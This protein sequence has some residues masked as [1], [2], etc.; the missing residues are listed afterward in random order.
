[1]TTKQTSRGLI[2]KTQDYKETSKLLFV[3]TPKGKKTLVAKG[4]KSFKSDLR[5]MSQYFT[6]IEFID[7]D[8]LMLD[9]KGAV[10]IDSFDQIKT[11]FSDLKYVSIILEIIDKLF[12]EDLPHDKLYELLVSFLCN[13]EIETASIA[14][15]LKVLYALGYGLNF[16]GN[17]PIGF[18][19]EHASVST[20][21]NHLTISLDL[22]TTVYLSQLYFMKINDTIEIPKKYRGMIWSFIKSFYQYHLE[23]TIKSIE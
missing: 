17:D 5:F 16:S 4:A 14:L 21:A 19:I 7:T 1:M 18:N 13:V 9:L 20:K 10:L 11:S 3:Y 15:S 2:Y 6:L 22:D 23:Y 8:K 12:I